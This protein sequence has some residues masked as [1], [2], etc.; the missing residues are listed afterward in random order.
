MPLLI[1]DTIQPTGGEFPA[2]KAKDVEFNG[3]P[4]TEYLA[5]TLTQS[6]YDELLADGKIVSTTQYFIYEEDSE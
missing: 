1:Y 5:V 6:E 3:R 4:I 2:V